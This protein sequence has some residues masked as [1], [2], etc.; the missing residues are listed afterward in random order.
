[1]S[2]LFH[3]SPDVMIIEHAKSIQ[4]LTIRLKVV[5]SIAIAQETLEGRTRRNLFPSPDKRLGTSNQI[6]KHAL[7]GHGGLVQIHLPIHK[8]ARVKEVFNTVDSTLL[9]DELILMN[10]KHEQNP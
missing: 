6:H 9:N 1:M 5:Q 2:P 10:V 3:R 8:A 7:C 4:N